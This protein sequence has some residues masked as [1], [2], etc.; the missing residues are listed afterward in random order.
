ML[1]SSAGIRRQVKMTIPV[2]SSHGV[3]YILFIGRVEKMPAS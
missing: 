2:D 3:S 1:F